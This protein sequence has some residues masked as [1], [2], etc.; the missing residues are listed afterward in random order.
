MK[1][2]K[3]FTFLT[4]IACS[5]ASLLAIVDFN[6]PRGENEMV[7]KIA[8]SLFWGLLSIGYFKFYLLISKKLKK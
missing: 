8:L 4:A 1:T 3:H 7:V 5:I 2:F 6:N